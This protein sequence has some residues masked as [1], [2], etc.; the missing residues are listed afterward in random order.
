MVFNKNTY[1]KCVINK[2]TKNIELD[3]F[4]MCTIFKNL[5]NLNSVN[6]VS[7][8]CVQIIKT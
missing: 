3:C 2:I 5:K 6:V 4:K 8:A 7:K 1:G